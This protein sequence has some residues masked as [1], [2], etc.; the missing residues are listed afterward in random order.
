[1]PL[2]QPLSERSLRVCVFCGSSDGDRPAYRELAAAVGRL[3]VEREAGVV[4]GGG[5][6]GCMGALADAALAAGGTVVGV[7][8]EALAAREAAHRGLTALHVVGSMHERKA[9][10][11]AQSDAFL[12]LPGGF[13]TLEEL[14]EVV[15]WRQL[16]YHDKPIA[17]VNLDGYYDALL[18]FCDRARDAE[19]VKP[20]DRASL[21][22]GGDPVATI[23]ALLA[24]VA[25]RA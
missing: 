11:A 14:F 23:D 5:G 2:E 18:D 15:T 3:L 1:M 25:S 13:G 16:G 12:A 22:A 24:R 20:G 9:L 6:L 7:I 19:F 17:V 10:M 8:P 21:H 4:Y